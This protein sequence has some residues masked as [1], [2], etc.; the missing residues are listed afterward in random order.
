[1]KQ[2]PLWLGQPDPYARLRHIEKLDPA[3]DY[4]EITNLFY[5]DFQSV[6]LLKS[7]NGFMFTFAAPRISRVLGSTGEI[8]NR[9]AKRILD[10]TLLGSAVMKHGFGTPVG[11]EAA[12]RV[13]SMHSR[14]DI[15]ADDFVAVGIEEAI[16]SL[17]LAEKFGWR[18]VTD[19]E[20]E[21]VR[22][23]Y[24]YQA[25]AFGSP[26]PL[27]GSVAEMREFFDHY[28]D[29][30]LGFEPQNRRMSDA[31][32]LWF[33]KL[34]PAPLRPL[35]APFLLSHL[36]RRIA[37]ACEVPVPSSLT[38]RIAH[39]AMKRIG[40]RDPV[41]DGAPNKFEKMVRQIYPDGYE[42]SG[43][44]THVDEDARQEAAE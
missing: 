35:T 21:A 10:T 16:G 38:R 25:L 34:L 43:L 23:F 30:E 44:G 9:I 13:N 6:M 24:N 7:F 28:L 15:Q 40:R 4:L 5:A 18:A 39:Q 14:Y 17:D 20:R 27:P 26:R 42:L 36:D 2:K 41:P 12:R 11:R 32:M 8:D 33:R 29:T 31:F 1:M 19:I 22:I 37:E 3:K